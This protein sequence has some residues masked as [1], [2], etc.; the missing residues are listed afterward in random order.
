[1][2][3][4]LLHSAVCEVE[5]AT[6][7]APHLMSDISASISSSVMSGSSS[8]SVSRHSSARR[9]GHIIHAT[10]SLCAASRRS[11]ARLGCFCARAMQAWLYS[12][13]YVSC[14]VGSCFCA[15]SIQ[16]QHM[17]TRPNRCLGSGQPWRPLQNTPPNWPHALSETR[18]ADISHDHTGHHRTSTVVISDWYTPAASG[19]RSSR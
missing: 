17:H 9:H 19:K 6:S 13:S 7:P 10:I 15:V 2:R 1:M 11:S 14:C 18:P 8:S 4:S 12:S 5:R 16:C 3:I